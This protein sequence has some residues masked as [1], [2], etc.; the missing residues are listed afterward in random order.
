MNGYL[1]DTNVLSETYKRVP[2]A[3]VLAFAGSIPSLEIFTSSIAIAELRRGA[4]RKMLVDEV[5]GAKID[6]WI[7]EIEVLMKGRIHSVDVKVAARWGRVVAK[8]DRP[9]MDMLIA[10][11]A[12]EHNLVLVTRNVRDFQDLDLEILNP[13]SW[14]PNE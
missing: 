12:I 1:F 10:A 6:A 8:R 7:D 14:L 2:N 4:E 5:E 9:A 13:W 3:N 11:T